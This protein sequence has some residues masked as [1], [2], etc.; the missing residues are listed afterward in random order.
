MEEGENPTRL[1]VPPPV[2]EAIPI[3]AGPGHRSPPQLMASTAAS[4][5]IPE[6][7]PTR[8]KK[9]KRKK[10]KE[11]P[12]VAPSPSPRPPATPEPEPEAP[13][14]LPPETVSSES[15][16]P[17]VPRRKKERK[18]K[19]REVNQEEEAPAPAPAASPF[20]EPVEECGGKEAT[21]KRIGRKHEAAA[22]AAAALSQPADGKAPILEGEDK[23]PAKAG[24]EQSGQ[25]PIPCDVHP[26][27]GGG[28]AAEGP[29]PESVS[30]R[31]SSKKPRILSNREFIRMRIEAKKRQP[32]PQGLLD[33]IAK[34]ANSDPSSTEQDPKYSSP[35]GA[36][37][38]QFCYRPERPLNRNPVPLPR[39]PDRKAR[40]HPQ[41]H[42]VC[43]SSRLRLNEIPKAAKTTTSR[44]KRPRSASASGSQVKGHAKDNEKPEKKL[45]KEKKPRKPPPLLS[46][47]EKRSDKY[48]RLPLDQLVPPPRSPHKL[49]QE[50]YASD[51]WKVIVICMLL[52]LTQGK[53]V[54]KKVKGF[55]KCYPDAQTACDA[56]PE[57]MAEYLAPL[58]LQRVKTNRIQKFSK[59]YIGL[60]WTHVTELCG[61]GKYA[62]D[63]Y[64]I[65]C[66]GRATEVVPEDHKLV[67]YWKY[68]CFE[69]PA[70]QASQ[71]V[72]EP[73]VSEP[74]NVIP[75]VQELVGCC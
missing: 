54:R 1:A 15:E 49:L 63:A 16:P 45:S 75:K 20:L 40:L 66:A 42:P 51:P 59:A 67:D 50:K 38:D 57:K 44:V 36:F 17:P 74:E 26:Q 41:G 62:A 4:A 64:A 68:V 13:V 35:F 46:R 55:F 73:G 56:D 47:A 69:L 33:A 48:R 70:I 18:R 39:T 7:G 52:N 11:Q 5:V 53:Q 71:S 61:V 58:G 24:P 10:H 32:T 37:F 8:Q 21:K 19:K 28:E 60:E 6:E 29:K 43:G 3:L 25:S 22:A 27:G 12:E 9:R 34:A 2:A 31:S 65:F 72:Q 14:P 23:M 30:V